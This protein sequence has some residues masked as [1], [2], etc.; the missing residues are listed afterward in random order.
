MGKLGIEEFAGGADRCCLV[1]S[2][3]GAG[4][5]VGESNNTCTFSEGESDRSLQ[6]LIHI[7]AS[8]N[9]NVMM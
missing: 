6:I 2:A 3:G 8:Y 4:Q 7:I 9:V 1:P 5:V